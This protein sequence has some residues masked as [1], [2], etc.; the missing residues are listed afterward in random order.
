MLRS[1]VT[2]LG[3]YLFGAL[4]VAYL[5]GR[6]LKGVDI[7]DYGSGNVGPSNVWRHVWKP[8]VVPVGLAEIAQGAAGPLVAKRGGQGP[9][10]QSLAGAAALV[11]HNWSPFMGFTGGRGIGH[12][13]GYM[14]VVSKP[15]FAA[16]VMLSIIGVALRKV[17]QFV[18]FGVISMPLAA[19]A[20]RQRPETI[21]GN[22][23][24][25]GAIVTKRL[26]ANDNSLPR[27]RVLLYRLLYDRDTKEREAWVARAREPVEVR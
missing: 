15:A 23:I 21:A 16:F 5:T 17:P 7:R 13:I 12:A 24:V 8:A 27:G 3:S 18:L 14:L 2:V 19:L 11:G 20:A 22:A 26:L 1:L 6:L 4:P 10:A 25:A 9:A